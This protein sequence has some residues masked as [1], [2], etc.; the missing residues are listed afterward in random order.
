MDKIVIVTGANSGLGKGFAVALLEA[1]FTVVGTVRKQEMVAHFEQLRPGAAFARVLDVT[2]TPE[3]LAAFVEEVEQNVGPVY[4]L[5]NNAG[6]GHEGT[7]EESSIVELRQQFEVNVFGAVSMM[8]AVLP[9][10]RAR[11]EGRILNVTSMGGLMTMP[12]LSYYH[13]SK[14][15]LEGISSSLAKEVRPLGIY[16][17]AVEPGMFRTDWAGRSMVRSL[18]TISDYDAIFDPIREARKARSG[19]QPGDPVKA[20]KVIAEFLTSPEPPLHLLLGKDALNY[21]DKE[22]EALHSEITMWEGVTRTTDFEET[23]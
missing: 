7:L 22:L 16:V 8:K 17:T 23:A 5:I 15:A 2:D 12:G 21:V 9:H 11:R 18:R 20:G 14:F 4:A 6:Y 13:G 3:H 19:H 10:M 1:G